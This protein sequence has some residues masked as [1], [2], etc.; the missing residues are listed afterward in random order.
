MHRCSQG[1]GHSSWNHAFCLHSEMVKSL[2]KGSRLSLTQPKPSPYTYKK[3]WTRLGGTLSSTLTNSPSN[4]QTLKLRRRSTSSSNHHHRRCSLSSISSHR[5]QPLKLRRR[6]TSSSNHP[7][8]DEEEDSITIS[9]STAV[10]AFLVLRVGAGGVQMGDGDVS[11]D[12]ARDAAVG[13]F[14]ARVTFLGR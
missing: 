7:S 13:T 4:H 10:V 5:R 6:T 12:I 14:V 2:K 3:L 11:S 9:A 1:G 8:L